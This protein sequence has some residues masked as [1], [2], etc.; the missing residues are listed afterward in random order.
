[1]H[2][3]RLSESAKN[4]PLRRKAEKAEVERLQKTLVRIFAVRSP[5]IDLGCN[6]ANITAN[7]GGR[8]AAD[9]T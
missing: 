2:F 9:A 4:F 7:K 8:V 1:M 5:L 3:I 6:K